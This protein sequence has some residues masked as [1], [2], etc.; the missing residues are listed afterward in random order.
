MERVRKPAKANK[1]LNSRGQEL[2]LYTQIKSKM[3]TFSKIVYALC[4]T[5]CLSVCANGQNFSIKGIV[6]DAETGVVLKGA[7]IKIHG[8]TTGCIS[9]EKGEF[10]IEKIPNGE[11]EIKA[12]YTG[13]QTER[14]FIILNKNI[15]NLI[16]GLK[17]SQIDL[18]EVTVTGTGSHYKLKNSPIQT[19]LISKKTIENIGSTS[20]ENILTTVSSSFDFSPS[21]GMGTFSH[22]NGLG[23][24]YISF[25]INGRKIIGDISGNID[26]SRVNTENIEKIEIVKGAS[27]SLYGSDAIGGVV[28]IITKNNSHNISVSNDSQVGENGSFSENANIGLNISKVQSTTNYNY[29]KADFYKLLPEYEE[30]KDYYVYGYDSK[31]ISQ[32]LKL[33]AT[34]NLSF[35]IGG[36]YFK[37]KLFTPEEKPGSS[38]D[39]HYEDINYYANAK[40]L[41]NKRN[42]IKLDISQSTYNQEFYYFKDKGDI[43]AGDTQFNKKQTTTTAHLKGVFKIGEKNTIVTGI[44][45]INEM[46]ETTKE[47][48]IDGKKTYNTSSIYAQDIYSP[49]ENL[50][51]VIGAR[52][53][54]NS[55]FGTEL[56]PKIS[57]MYKLYDF[58]IRATYSHGFKTPSLQELYYDYESTRTY[59]YSVGNKDLKAEKSRY[60]NISIEFVKSWLNASI[61]V[62][63]NDIQDM[64][65]KKLLTDKTSPLFPQQ[66]LD[67]NYDVLLYSNIAEART[68]GID[69]N[70]NSYLGQGFTIGGGYSFVDAKNLKTNRQLDRT[71]RNYANIK[72]AWDKEWKFYAMNIT[73]TGKYQDGKYYSYES[74]NLVKNKTTKKLE[75]KYEFFDG[76][77][78]E[79]NLW[80][81]TTNHKF[82][83]KNNLNISL[84]AGVDNIFNYT[85]KKPYTYKTSS[86]YYG[87]LTPGRTYFFGIKLN[88]T[89]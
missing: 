20:V 9:N 49:I 46:L 33:D 2:G 37:K 76:T 40:Y 41:I 17:K 62:Y 15:P 24:K 61:S 47:K 19:E 4:I 60:Y 84:Y 51:F 77:T 39:Y 44:E 22:I 27:S 12:S 8:T 64:I 86:Y 3:K 55:M 42:Y 70:I 75:R 80:R 13:Y 59:S 45:H 85:E 1:I 43:K 6:K 66:H 58:N 74:N 36:N 87:T 52:G 25:M 79:Y 7:S 78:P 30:A 72:L 56:S 63:R 69:F 57:S 71:G 38:Y 16:F 21:A 23:S 82:I 53:V 65:D 18:D 81:L 83:S 50:S 31:N 29:K 54:N 35:N 68:Q 73:L 5:M 14:S 89:K 10:L 28:N 32:D 11:I 26:L 67:Y 88:F 48:I 34:Q